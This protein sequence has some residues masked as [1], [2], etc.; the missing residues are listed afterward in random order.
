MLYNYAT[1]ILVQHQLCCTCYGRVYGEGKDLE[2]AKKKNECFR[3]RMFTGG[4]RVLL[5]LI[6]SKIYVIC[7]CFKSSINILLVL[8]MVMCTACL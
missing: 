5:I 3:V 6:F 8:G 7:V 4:K 1:S 2:C